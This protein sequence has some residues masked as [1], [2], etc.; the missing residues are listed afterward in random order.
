MFFIC[1]L[2]FCIGNKRFVINGDGY[3]NKKLTCHKDYQID[4]NQQGKSIETCENRCGT[5]E[6]CQFYFYT[7]EGEWCAHYSACDRTREPY[8]SGST[9]RKRSLSG[10]ILRFFPFK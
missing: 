4:D 7:T 1:F 5:D 2:K 3:D 10:L 8:L 9:Y 6:R